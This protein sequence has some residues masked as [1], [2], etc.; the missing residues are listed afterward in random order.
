MLFLLYQSTQARFCCSNKPPKNLSGLSSTKVCFSFMFHVVCSLTGPGALFTPGCRLKRQPTPCHLTHSQERRASGRTTSWLL[1]LL[2]GGLTQMLLVKGSHTAKADISGES[3]QRTTSR[4][5][6][7]AL[8]IT[9]SAT[10]TVNRKPPP[11]AFDKRQNVTKY[12]RN[13]KNVNMKTFKFIELWPNNF[14]F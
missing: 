11:L 12:R 3:Y 8:K 9:Q 10:S 7:Y 6:Q 13:D 5:D 4:K 2:L 14:A 1:E